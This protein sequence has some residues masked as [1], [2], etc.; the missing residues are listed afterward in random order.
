MNIARILAA[1]LVTLVAIGPWHA[2]SAQNFPNRPLKLIVSYPPG[3]V[4]DT[5]G[6]LDAGQLAERLGQPVIVDNKPGASQTIGAE[7]T[8][9]SPPD[10][11]TLFLG[12][13]SSLILQVGAK[14]SLPYDPVKDFAPVS[15][16]FNLPLY[17]VVNPELPVKNV[18]ELIAYARA[19]P[20]TLTFAS[21]GAGSTVHLAG[22]MFKKMAGVE[23]VH[24]PYKGSAPALTDIMAGRVSLMFDG[25]TSALPFV[26]AGKLRVLAT[27]DSRRSD[28]LPDIPTIAESGLPGYEAVSWFGIA[29][30]AGTPHP[31]LERL[32]ADTAAIVSRPDFKAKFVG[33]GMEMISSTPDAMAEMIR[34]G[35]PRW[36]EVMRDAGIRPE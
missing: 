31:I 13:T 14:K 20:R 2:A 11:Y 16:V 22:E 36:T 27:T 25:G 24:V 28:Q 19:N 29:A 18:R 5:F 15:L 35:I 7:A 26:K 12:S 30:P 10:G 1:T 34:V 8:V 3:G 6:R 23:M 32:A 33:S 17:L 9:K 21:I 4:G